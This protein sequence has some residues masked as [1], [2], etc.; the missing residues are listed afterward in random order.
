ML[1]SIVARLSRPESESVVALCMSSS[2]PTESSTN[3]IFPSILTSVPS[4]LSL[5]DSKDCINPYC[6][7]FQQMMIDTIHNPTIEGSHKP[8]GRKTSCNAYCW[9]KS[10]HQWISGDSKWMTEGNSRKH[11]MPM[12]TFNL[13]SL[14][15]CQEKLP[16]LQSSYQQLGRTSKRHMH[17]IQG[18]IV[19]QTEHCA[20]IIP[21]FLCGW[22]EKPDS[23]T[24]Q[25]DS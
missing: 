1:R 5:R 11:Q 18:I 9:H 15:T 12:E 2:I 7:V 21:H 16:I 6:N 24:I 22:M 25:E 17:W 14:S 23:R 20:I 8:S 13:Q 4:P 3:D 19:V 10:H